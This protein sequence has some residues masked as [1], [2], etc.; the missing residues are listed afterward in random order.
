MRVL[1]QGCAKL[2]SS[3]ERW[4]FEGG[5]WRPA[6]FKKVE[7]EVKVEWEGELGMWNVECGM[8]GWRAENW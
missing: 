3:E 6:E 5:G 8:R 7:V 4:R 2:V 1:G